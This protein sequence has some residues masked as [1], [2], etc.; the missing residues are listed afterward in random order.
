ME[1]IGMV[2]V[3]GQV[4]KDKITFSKFL[5]PV[6]YTELQLVKIGICMEFGRWKLSSSHYTLKAIMLRHE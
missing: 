4:G 2:I 1:N 6:Y 3:P 5:K